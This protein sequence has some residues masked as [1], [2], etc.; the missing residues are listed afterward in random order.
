MAQPLQT[1]SSATDEQLILSTVTPEIRLQRR[2]ERER[3]KRASEIEEQN[4]ED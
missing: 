2:R 1:A 4:D 3:E